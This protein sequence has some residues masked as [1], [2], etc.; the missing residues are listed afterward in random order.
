MSF[1]FQRRLKMGGVPFGDVEL[2]P[3]EKGSDKPAIGHEPVKTHDGNVI[4]HIQTKRA[5]P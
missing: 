2:R 3:D 4:K 1:Y 5:M